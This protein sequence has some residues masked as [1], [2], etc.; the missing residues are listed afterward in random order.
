MRILMLAQFY[1]PT[2]GGEERHVADLSADL[3]ARGHDVSVATLWHEGPPRFE[4]ARGVRIHR[5]RGTMQ[6]MNAIF[7][8]HDRQFSPPFTDPEALWALKKV[9]SEERPDVI[10]AHNWIVH[11]VTPL[12]AWSKARLVMTLHDYSLVCVQKRL[13]RYGVR[14]SGPE[15][16]KCLSCATNFYGIGKGVPIRL[17]NLAWG[18][19]ERRTV[20]MFLPVSHSVADQTYLEKHN[21]PYRIVPNFIPDDVETPTEDTDALL[22]Q[23]PKGDFLLYVG[24]VMPDKG[25]GV[26][27][28]AHASL[29]RQIPLVLI[30]RPIDGYLESFPPNVL[31]L[32]R[33][34]HN[35]IMQ[36]W[37]RCTIALVPSICPDACPTVAMEAMVMGQPIIASRIGGL[38][39]IVV[40]GVTGLLVTPGD[41]QELQAAIQ[42]VLDD[43]ELRNC[44]RMMAM[45]R[46][47]EFQA[48]SVVPRIEQ[49][50][51]EVL[52]SCR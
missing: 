45:K 14:C 50:Y 20:D 30:G 47:E 36:A 32:G 7:S 10:H 41:S 28:Q 1:P 4:V 6:R 49:V 13:M 42:R 52:M 43:D 37:K 18:E 16:T 27:L 24:D 9:I 17:A 15:F 46:V 25:I 33:W 26:L 48:K 12:K 22:A 38:I 21:V 44:M 51:R 11:S 40:D 3:A 19:L 34:P 8:Y 31:Y 35:A 29:K 2:I 23:L 39:D 5:I